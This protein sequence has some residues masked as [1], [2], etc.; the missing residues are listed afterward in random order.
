[1][2]D[3]EREMQTKKTKIEKSKGDQSCSERMR[4]K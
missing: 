3:D 1:M 2:I 4:T